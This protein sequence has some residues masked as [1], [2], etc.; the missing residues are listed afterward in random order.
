[1]FHD[2][3]LARFLPTFAL[4]AFGLCFA[5]GASAFPEDMFDPGA[6]PSEFPDHSG[7][8]NNF[9]STFIFSF[10]QGAGLFVPRVAI[11]CSTCKFPVDPGIGHT[12]TFSGQVLGQI[13][14]NNGVVNAGTRRVYDLVDVKITGVQAAVSEPTDDNDDGISEQIIQYTA[15]LLGTAPFDAEVSG[16]LV[17]NEAATLKFF[18]LTLPAVPDEGTITIG[19]KVGPEPGDTTDGLITAGAGQTFPASQVLGQAVAA[20]VVFQ[21]TETKRFRLPPSD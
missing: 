8:M 6:P 4:A 11:D 2:R 14:E 3:S 15:N 12:F 1:M 10:S 20:N 17:V 9:G 18:P 13:R 5:Q 16:Q 21:V 7:E 19:A